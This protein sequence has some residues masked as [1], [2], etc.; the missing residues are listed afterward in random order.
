MIKHKVFLL[1]LLPFVSILAVA[2][3]SWIFPN[4]YSASIAES[5]PD[6]QR[7]V[8]LTYQKALLEY[9]SNQYDFYQTRLPGDRYLESESLRITH[10]LTTELIPQL[11]RLSRRIESAYAQEV[12]MD[13]QRF[14]DHLNAEVEQKSR[15]YFNKLLEQRQTYLSNMRSSFENLSI[16]GVVRNANDE[17]QAFLLEIPNQTWF[18]SGSARIIDETKP[19]LDTIL[20][21]FISTNPQLLIGLELRGHTDADGERYL[22]G[23]YDIMGLYMDIP[24]DMKRNTVLD[25][26]D[27]NGQRKEFRYYYLYRIIPSVPETEYLVVKNDRYYQE[28]LHRNQ[29][30]S[31]DRCRAIDRYFAHHNSLYAERRLDLRMTGVAF[32]EPV[33]TNLPLAYNSTEERLA[34]RE[35]KAANRR[36]EFRFF[37]STKRLLETI[38]HNENVLI[39]LSF[40]H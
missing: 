39:Q 37:L 2:L 21:T 28:S 25:E 36:M 5:T 10:Y 8:N 32:L 27:G 29:Q 20:E 24:L 12:Q 30:L 40:T 4:D 17:T 34:A 9:Q 16:P 3:S 11:D 13:I 15:N 19:L 33:T 1:I 38:A 31:I 18:T 6:R 23:T 14:S 26:L 22:N 35:Q 7:Y